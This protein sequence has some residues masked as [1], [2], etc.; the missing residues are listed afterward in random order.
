MKQKLHPLCVVLLALVLCNTPLFAHDFEVGGMYYHIM[1][2]TDKT[3]EVTYRGSKYNSYTN[4]YSGT[5]TIPESVTYSGSTYSVTS[6]GEF[7]F[8][9]CSSLTSVEIPN[10]VTSIGSMAFYRCSSLTSVVIPNSVT[11]IGKAA[12]SGCYSLTSV[13]IPNSVTSIGSSAFGYCSSLISVEIPNSVTSIGDAAFSDC[14]N[15]TSITVA[16]DNTT[17]DSRNNCNAIIET[18]TNT[19]IA[20]CYKTTIPNSVTSIGDYAFS[21]CPNLTSVVIPNSVTSIGISAFSGCSG[22]TSVE[23]PN[24]VTNIGEA[25]F[26]GCSGLTSVVIPNSV[27]SIGD[28]A[29]FYCSSLTSVEIPNSV[30]SIGDYAFAHCSGLTSV[31]IP[32][33][34]TNIGEAAFSDCSSL[35]SIAVAEGNQTYDSR[36]NCNA[37]IET[38]T[39]TLIVGCYKTTIPNSVTSIGIYAF[40][41]CSS[42]TSVEIPNSVTSIGFYAFYGCFSLT[43]VE[44]PNSVTSI[45]E[46]AFYGCFDLKTVTVGCSWKTN[47]H[48]YFGENV[49]VN[50]T[51]HSYENGV[52]TVCGEEETT[53]IDGITNNAHQRSATFD[54]HGRRVNKA[55]KG[56]Y[57]I[58][59]KK[60]MIK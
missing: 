16:E 20:G 34:V 44:I 46:A 38:K 50:A 10:S 51:L 36:N 32:N 49:T 54:L 23:I 9:D 35:T 57:I 8:N 33:S 31:E 24:S 5:V 3:V 26:R 22:L 37:I 25:A 42:L 45:G 30:T 11:S 27:T 15:L 12:F 2:D 1:S 14:S 52:C 41:F 39:N 58:N 56:L 60:V 59:G 19:L 18:K 53:G 47:P 48:Y 55:G 17:Y 28:Y 4:E 43:S 7:A 40:Q 13:E 29:F 6:I 21:N